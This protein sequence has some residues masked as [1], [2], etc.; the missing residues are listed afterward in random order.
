[1]TEE[2]KPIPPDDSPEGVE[3]VGNPSQDETQGVQETE[4]K[5]TGTTEDEAKGEMAAKEEAQIEEDK[6]EVDAR[7]EIEVEESAG[8]AKPGE[9]EEKAEEAGTEVVEE[10][11][12][13]KAEAEEKRKLLKKRAVKRKRLK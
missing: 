2:A 3:A 10:K 6:G 8:E 13:E 7:E 5:V 12:E 1:M 9:K 4:E 11:V